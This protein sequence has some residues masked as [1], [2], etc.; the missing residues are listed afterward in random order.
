M[1]GKYDAQYLITLKDGY[2]QTIRKITKETKRF[3][4]T[5]KDSNHN[6]KGFTSA[7]AK[8]GLAVTAFQIVQLGRDVIETTARFDA[9]R[10]SINFLSGSIFEGGESIIF[11]DEMSNKLGL[12]FQAS[13]EGFQTLVAGFRGTNES[14]RNIKQMFESVSV[15]ATAMGL[16]VQRQKLVMLAL[17]Q[18]AS[19]GVVSMEELRRQLG[20]SLPGAMAIG[21]RAMGMTISQFMK[22]VAEGKV[23]SSE[24]LPK[25]AEEV[26]KTFEKALPQAVKSLRAN[27]NRFQSAIF[28][29]KTAIGDA[30]TPTVN[31]LMGKLINFADALVDNIDAIKKL[32]KFFAYLLKVFIAYKSA[33]FIVNKAQLIFVKRTAT[34][35][36]AMMILSGKVGLATRSIQGLS[37][38]L[39]TTAWGISIAAVGLIVEKIIQWRLEVRKT[40][41]EHE[42]LM[43]QKTM[44]SD[45]EEINR[46]LKKSGVQTPLSF[47]AIIPKKTDI[48]GR[49]I[50]S[51]AKES[52]L[53]TQNAF[54]RFEQSVS[55]EVP[56]T[57]ERMQMSIGSAVIEMQRE[58]KGKALPTLKELADQFSIDRNKKSVNLLKAYQEYLR[59]INTELEKIRNEEVIKKLGVEDDLNKL[60]ASSPKVFNINIH[61]LI[62]DFTVNTGNVEETADQIRE[63][64]IETINLALADLQTMA[65]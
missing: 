15:G 50:T 28:K 38:A 7:L 44:V 26:K 32:T 48:W 63:K 56:A 21:A 17:G 10:K 54:K 41:K 30:F 62:D 23:M 60:T 4:S 59:I 49:K 35:R 27:L 16:S 55:T 5:I 31:N 52:L 53:V 22:L 65:R 36:I 12:S 14:L 3:N 29:T 40:R 2:S 6:M 20:D 45:A 46:F 9:M 33:L 39:R 47:G 58:L 61:K 64:V 43:K 34:M 8:A 25:F 42:K 19:K 13:M 11:L 18:I 24:F 1:P 51:E 57:L 37:T